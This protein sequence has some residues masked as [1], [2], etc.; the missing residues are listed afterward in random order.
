MNAP[1]GPDEPSVL[2]VRYTADPVAWHGIL[3]AM[4]AAGPGDEGVWAPYRLASGT[5]VVHR[6][7]PTDP[8]CGSTLLCLAV[9]DPAG[10]TGSL[11]SEI[12]ELLSDVDTGAGRLAR[13]T[14]GDGVHLDILPAGPAPMGEIGSPAVQAIW[15]SDRCPEVA[16][17][18]TGLGLRQTLRSVSG[19]WFDLRAPGGGAVGVHES[20]EP[21]TELAFEHPDVGELADRLITAGIQVVLIDESY[22]RTLRIPDPDGGPEVW[23]NEVITDLYGFVR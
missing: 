8:R 13:I 16:M 12:R 2:A 23:V 11:S 3:S 9:L 21:H 4:G 5:V 7:E 15:Y 17:T 1:T 19:G 22:A 18:L 6:V 10:Y 14:G 20:T